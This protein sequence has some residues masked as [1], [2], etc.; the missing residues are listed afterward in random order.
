MATRLAKGARGGWLRFRV[1]PAV[2]S[3]PPDLDQRLQNDRRF[4]TLSS[5]AGLAR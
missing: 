3:W 1:A 4:L 5:V 2:D